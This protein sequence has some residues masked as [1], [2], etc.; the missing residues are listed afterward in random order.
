MDIRAPSEQKNPSIETKSVIKK[1]SRHIDLTADGL[2][3]ITSHLGEDHLLDLKPA[4]NDEKEVKSL[5]DTIIKDTESYLTGWTSNGQ[6]T[7]LKDSILKLIST[8]KIK[9]KKIVDALQDN[10][11]QPPLLDMLY[12]AKY[13]F[14]TKDLKDRDAYIDAFKKS[15]KLFAEAVGADQAH[16]FFNTCLLEENICKLLPLASSIIKT[17]STQ[18]EDFNLSEIIAH[19]IAYAIGKN[20]GLVNK[21]VINNQQNQPLY[22]FTVE[23]IRIIKNNGQRELGLMGA[24]LTPDPIDNSAPVS[25]LRM[26]WAGTHSPESAKLNSE[27]TPGEETYRR[28]ED[29]VLTYILAKMQAIYRQNK[30]PIRFIVS[31]HSL[32]GA[33]SQLTLHSLQRILVADLKNQEAGKQWEIDFQKKLIT[34]TAGVE[35]Q[36]SLAGLKL[37]TEFVSEMALEAW[38]SPGVL[39]SVADHSNKMSP[40][41]VDNGIVLRAKYGMVH[42]DAVQTSGLKMVLNDVKNNKAIIILL[43]IQ[44]NSSLNLKTKSLA[45]V[46]ALSVGKTLGA[47]VIGGPIGATA[48]AVTVGGATYASISKITL[49][50]HRMHHFMESNR[51]LYPYVLLT[52]RNLD[53]SINISENGCDVICTELNFKSLIVDAGTRAVNYL[54]MPEARAET[55]KEKDDTLFNTAFKQLEEKK[56][57]AHEIMTLLVAEMKSNKP[58]KNERI[59]KIIDDKR[60]PLYSTDQAGKT[61]LHHAIELDCTYLVKQLLH[62][63]ANVNHRDDEGNTPLMVCM[64]SKSINYEIGLALLAQPAVNINHKNHKGIS[65]RSIHDSWRAYGAP[66]SLARQFCLKLKTLLD[67][68]PEDAF[69]A[70]MYRYLNLLS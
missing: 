50:A 31:G 60:F 67:K 18:I 12:Q 27:I 65:A 33:L 10:K 55:L 8:N 24:F 7:Y 64:L 43:K 5:T 32:G 4:Q 16:E 62:R 37:A 42:G 57:S 66:G 45:S 34:E 40:A 36:R 59:L 30:R 53:G 46:S 61:L 23:E 28:N 14:V 56:S 3:I 58:H 68:T 22:A 52:S 6:K 70:N 19:R 13:I 69:D 47:A 54:A 41:L 9:D 26:V 15:F 21:V 38:N 17:H 49:D 20:P 25:T 39:E 63:D 51:P 29:Q 48:T 35:H 11:L 2:L 44:P 1:L